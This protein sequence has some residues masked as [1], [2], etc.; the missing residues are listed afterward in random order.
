MVSEY[1]FLVWNDGRASREALFVTSVSDSQVVA[2]LGKIGARPGNNL[3]MDTWDKRHEAKHPAPQVRI[4]GT[5]LTIH[6]LWE[7]SKNEISI[8]EL[9]DDSGGGDKGDDCF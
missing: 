4:A 3:T 8:S 2:A 9:L 7:N 1:H 6:I 5:S